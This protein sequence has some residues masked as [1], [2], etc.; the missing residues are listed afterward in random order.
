M[1]Q[2][3]GSIAVP[4]PYFLPKEA[5]KETG[6]AVPPRTPLGV[7]CAGECHAGPVPQPASHVLCNF[8]YARGVCER[9]PSKA[10]ADA[11]RFVITARDADVIHVR[12]LFERA[13]SP[14][15]HGTLV[16]YA[17]EGRLVGAEGSPILGG[18]V[19]SFLR[20]ALD[21]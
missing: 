9:F 19:E 3:L 12:Y 1:P 10:P 16:Y 6:W 21:R 2:Q 15:S 18:Q 5:L 20:H 7:L 4:C 14:Q 8:G 11:I 17:S 13:C